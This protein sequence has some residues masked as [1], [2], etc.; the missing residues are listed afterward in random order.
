MQCKLFILV[1]FFFDRYLF[2]YYLVFVG[3][4]YL[5]LDE[6]LGKLIILVLYIFLIKGQL[7]VVIAVLCN[8]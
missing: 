2:F 7:C 4:F 8:V 1:I 3:E 6:E 5:V